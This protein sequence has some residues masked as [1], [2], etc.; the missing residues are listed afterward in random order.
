MI[1]DKERAIEREVR[2]RL[3]RKEIERLS[4]Q[5]DTITAQIAKLRKRDKQI[6]QEIV[7]NNDEIGRLIGEML[8]K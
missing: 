7:T 2:L 3:A 5:R 8:V 1:T 6:A 4:E